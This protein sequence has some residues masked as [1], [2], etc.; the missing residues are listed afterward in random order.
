MAAT[1]VANGVVLGRKGVGEL[2]RARALTAITE[3]AGELGVSAVTVAHVV[4]RSGVSRRT[5][6]ELFD[7]R[8]DCLRVAFEQAV[9]RAAAVVLPAYAAAKE[10]AAASGSGVWETQ[11]RAGLG[12]TLGFMDAEP[13]LGRLLVV[14]ALAA[15]RRLLESRARV[16]E[17]LVDVVHEGG[18]RPDG[19]SGRRPKR[20]VAEGAVG[21]VLA[22]MHA[23]LS[24]PDPKPMGGLLGQLLGIV[25][26][27]YLGAEAAEREQRRRAPR[28]RRRPAPP[29]D[30][31]RA[32][33]MRLTYRT[34][35]VLLAIAELS[36]KGSSPSSREVADAAGISDQGQISKLL[37]RLEHLDLIANGVR[38]QGRG[39][40]NAWSLTAKG[41]EVQQAI[42]SQIG[43]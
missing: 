2:Q 13:A 7:D 18:A 21:A 43:V 29:P 5:F 38:R 10:N 9:Q 27:P 32:L 11:I 28:A 8:D 15:D 39:E 16:V 14:D 30:P 1:A 3:L 6:Y 22:V 33:D 12:A 35:R 36:G 31:L 37:H 17:A 26:L 40:S 23:R 41:L 4:E 20:I 19:R 24:E 42:E 34:V 25:V